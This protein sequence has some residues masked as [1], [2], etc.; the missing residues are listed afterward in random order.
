MTG[1]N[2]QD[3]EP[4]VRRRERNRGVRM[5]VTHHNARY[6]KL[7]VYW[8]EKQRDASDR[9]FGKVVPLPT[10]A[11]VAR[12][13]IGNIVHA[14][15][16]V[17][18]LPVKFS[19]MRRNQRTMVTQDYIVKVIGNKSCM[20]DIFSCFAVLCDRDLSSVKPKPCDLVLL[21]TGQHERL[22]FSFSDCPVVIDISIVAKTNRNLVGQCFL[23]HAADTH[24]G[25]IA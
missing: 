23:V 22:A 9:R 8:R 24:I 12:K 6:A 4:R 15:Q 20:P 10:S 21:G 17:E 13:I 25:H 2:N 1:K 3:L 11:R 5:T 14:E 7:R 18:I 16:R 19:G